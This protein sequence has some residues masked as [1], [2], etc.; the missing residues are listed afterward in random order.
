MTKQ[1]VI[2]GATGSIGQSTLSVISALEPLYSVAVVTAY[3]RWKE[4]ARICRTYQPRMA[5]IGDAHYLEPLRKELSDTDIEISSGEE[6][7]MRAASWKDADIFVTGIVGGIGLTATIE[8]VKTGKR[9]G[10]ANK[11][12]F[13]MAGR[14]LTDLI[15][16]SGAEIIP[17]DSEH[18]AIFQCL[19]GEPKESIRRIFLT[20]SGGPFRSLPREQLEHVTV[21][22]ALNHPTWNMGPKITIDSAT[23]MN[24]A[25]EIIEARWL[26]GVN[27]SRIEVLIHPQSV[28]HSMVSFVDGSVKAQ[29]GV[30]DMKVPIQYALTYPKRYAGNNE[31][32]DFIREGELTFEKPDM[33]KYPALRMGYDILKHTGDA[34][35][36]VLNAANE[37]VVELFLQKKLSFTS[38]TEFIWRA[39][40]NLGHDNDMTLSDIRALDLETRQFIAKET[41][42]L[43]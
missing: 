33:E 7:L 5:V 4:L 16:S 14:L 37:A 25:L 40:H 32:L 39:L 18:S 42:C 12:P 24:K 29:L 19:S 34:W 1:V 6:G 9:I 22:Q 36:V 38:M 21:E 17:I 2:L 10:I 13:V 23:M 11:E 3:S 26:F 15:Q 28:I 43:S 30:P 41:S 27:H 35:G 20:G 31:H 8:A